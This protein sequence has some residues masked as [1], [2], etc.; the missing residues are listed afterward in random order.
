MNVES[1]VLVNARRQSDAE[2]ASYAHGIIAAMV[3]NP[4][5][6][7]ATPYVTAVQDCYD[8]YTAK[9]SVAASGNRAQVA[10]KNVAKADLAVKV[11][12]LGNYINLTTPNDRPSQLTTA[13]KMNKETRTP[14]VLEPIKEFTVNYGAVSGSMDLFV[15]KGKGTRSVV[16]E[17]STTPPTNSTQWRSCTATRGKCTITGLTP[18]EPVW[19]RAA[20]IG[21]RD[22]VLYTLPIQKLVV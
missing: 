18:A 17:Y 3:A 21:S 10:E 22:Q 5:Y 1:K 12:A 7:L 16:F 14:V 20:A 6:P 13:F 15:K 4:K 19:S 2:A 8:T 9:L 11:A